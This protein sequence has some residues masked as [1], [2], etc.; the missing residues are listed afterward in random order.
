VGGKKWI[1]EKVVEPSTIAMP[2]A[3]T[4]IS[5]VKNYMSWQSNKD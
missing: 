1:L 5:E 4:R 2:E 3:T